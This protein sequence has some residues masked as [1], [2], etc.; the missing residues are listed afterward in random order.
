MLSCASVKLDKKWLPLTHVCQRIYKTNSL[1][2]FSPY[3]FVDDIKAWKD[4][5][6]IHREADL[7]H[8]RV[9]AIRQDEVGIFMY[10]LHYKTNP[11]FRL[12]EEK[13]AYYIGMRHYMRH[14]HPVDTAYYANALSSDTYEGMI[15]YDEAKKWV[16]DVVSGA[17]NPKIDPKYLVN[18]EQ[19]VL[20]MR[21]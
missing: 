2:A 18:T 10:M 12:Q 3:V 11:K 21:R 17:Y 5:E 14:G 8:E 13:L 16:E 19:E 15:S 4:Q 20:A 6:K 1:W 7:V 9:H